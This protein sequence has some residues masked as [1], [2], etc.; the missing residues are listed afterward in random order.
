MMVSPADLGLHNCVQDDIYI[1]THTYIHTYIHI[2]IAWPILPHEGS[3]PSYTSK[4]SPH[5][6]CPGR[7]QG[8]AQRPALCANPPEDRSEKRWF[9]TSGYGLG[10]CRA[11]GPFRVY[12][13]GIWKFQV[14]KYCSQQ[15][16]N[17]VG[18]CFGV[19]AS[20]GSKA[21]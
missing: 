15:G 8:N 3:F 1:Y 2:N 12:H 5:I 7:L 4:F 18:V 13:F 14:Y 17:A 19:E 6:R 10:F 16:I 20:G 21:L 11:E 9:S